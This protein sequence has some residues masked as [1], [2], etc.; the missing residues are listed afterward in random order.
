MKPPATTDIPI[1]GIG[2]GLGVAPLRAFYLDAMAR[3]QSM[4]LFYGC[5]HPQMDDVLSNQP[6]IRTDDTRMILTAYSRHEPQQYV[7]DV[8]R[9]YGAVVWQWIDARQ[10][11]I[12]LC[13]YFVLVGRV[14][15]NVIGT[16][17]ECQTTS[18]MRCW[19]FF[20]DMAS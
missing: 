4:M 7:Q 14:F 10:A 16:Q 11:C 6:D 8:M 19:I 5:R 13:G 17:N 18:R 12:Y 20:A 2:P 3:G 9:Q 15:I 1:I